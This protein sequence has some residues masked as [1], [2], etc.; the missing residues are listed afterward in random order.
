MSN[1]KKVFRFMSEKE[2]RAMDAYVPMVH[3]RHHFAARAGSVG[4]CFLDAKER[5][6]CFALKFLS[7][8]V[9]QDICVEFE[10]DE[11]YLTKSCGLYADPCSDCGDTIDVTEYCTPAYSRE[12]F[13]PVRYAFPKPYGWEIEWYPYN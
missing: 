3:P 7:G 5:N 2:F 8:I 12:M 10:V 6:A 11:K 1:T 9:S 4:F 13:K